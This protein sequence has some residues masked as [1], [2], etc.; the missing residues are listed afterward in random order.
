MARVLVV[1]DEENQ[2]R[3]LAIGLRLEG[4]DVST[5]RSADAALEALASEPVDVAIVDL[6]MPTYN[7]LDLARQMRERFPQ[8]RVVLTS[9]YH[10]SERQLARADCGVVGFGPKPYEMSELATFR[11]AKLTSSSRTPARR[12]ASMIGAGS[13]TTTSS[14]GN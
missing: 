5:A 7:G 9:A 12:S 3:V 11:R 13:T 8:T 2:V 10:L 14:W 1:D 6:M 4:F